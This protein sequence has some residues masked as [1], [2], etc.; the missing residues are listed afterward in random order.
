MSTIKKTKNKGAKHQVGRPGLAH[1]GIGPMSVPGA[2]D[3]ID[4]YK[5]KYGGPGKKNNGIG[6]VR[7]R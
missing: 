6:P 5:G 7:M 3:P 1:N 2:K 4:K